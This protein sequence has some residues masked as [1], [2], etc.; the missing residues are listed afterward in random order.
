MV[1]FCLS[2]L[3]TSQQLGLGLKKRQKRTLDTVR[4]LFLHLL[5]EE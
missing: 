1:N 5:L 4:Q 3:C 2:I